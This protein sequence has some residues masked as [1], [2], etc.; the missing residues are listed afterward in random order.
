MA[1]HDKKTFLNTVA[2][3]NVKIFK[4]IRFGLFCE[5]VYSVTSPPGVKSVN[6]NIALTCGRRF[7]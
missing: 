3:I 5:T 1:E 2:K 4:A 6:K 7:S